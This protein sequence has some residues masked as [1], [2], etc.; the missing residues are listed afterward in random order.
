MAGGG[1]PGS[2][3]KGEDPLIW[4][5]VGSR[6]GGRALILLPGCEHGPTLWEARAA[7]P[8][9]AGSVPRAR[10]PLSCLCSHL[11]TVGRHSKTQWG[12][13]L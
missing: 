13:L 11:H 2:R 5:R 7:S 12:L 8:G 4:A 9:K 3:G 10:G 6:W 1:L